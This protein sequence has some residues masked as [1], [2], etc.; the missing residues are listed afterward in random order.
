MLKGGHL[1]GLRI[2]DLPIA[3]GEMR[4]AVVFDRIAGGIR[5]APHATARASNVDSVRL[6]P[7]RFAV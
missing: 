6:R 3:A 4:R 1:R 2:G 5:H 7:L